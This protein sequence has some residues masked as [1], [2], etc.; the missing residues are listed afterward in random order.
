MTFNKFKNF[1]LVIHNAAQKGALLFLATFLAII[2]ANSSYKDC[3]EGFFN[4]KLSLSFDSYSF[5]L[6]LKDWINDLLMAVFFFSVGMEIKREFMVGHL[7]RNDQRVLPFFGA[8]GGIIVP[9]GIFIFF[10]KGSSDYFNGW[11]IP[12]ATDI[13]F[14][15]GVLG[16]VCKS[17]PKSLK[18]F[19]TALAIIDDI[20]AVLIIAIFYTTSLSMVHL[21]IACLLFFLLWLCVRKGLC[22]GLLYIVIGG[23]IWSCFLSSGVHATIAGVILGFFVPIKMNDGRKIIES[24]E[25]TIHPIVSYFIMPVFAFANSGLSFSGLTADVLFNP[26]VLG[27]ALGL[28]LGKQLG[29]FGMVYMLIKAKIASLPDGTNLWQFYGV[30]ILCGIGFTMSLFIGVLAFAELGECMSLVKVGVIS[31]SLLSCIFGAIVLNLCNKS[32]D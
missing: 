24:F 10:N 18:V 1:T 27:I 30:S 11:A 15:L 21:L 26:L 5:G 7:S 17:L 29:V 25:S 4:T 28:F 8:L 12:A 2:I 6:S 16:V 19:L 20:I 13:A 31:G 3:Y 22:S 14:A 9:I 23:V 32:N